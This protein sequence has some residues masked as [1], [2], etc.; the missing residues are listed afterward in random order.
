VGGRR[1]FGLTEKAQQ[2][3]QPDRCLHLNRRG[4]CRTAI[5]G[6]A[7]STQG[8]TGPDLEDLRETAR[9]A[10]A[11]G[12]DLHAQIRDLT[13]S[14]FAT[15]TLDM[16][17]VREVTRSV[18]QGVS[19]ATQ[20]HGGDAGK[21]VRE[22]IAAIEDAILQAAQASTLAVREAGDRTAQ[23][24]SQDLKRALDDLAALQAMLLE[25]FSDTV[26]AG[27][28]TLTAVLSDFLDHARN[29]GEA[30]GQRLAEGLD[31]LQRQLPEAGKQ[32]LQ[33]G[34]DAV[35]AGASLLTQVASG[36][37]VGIGES[38]RSRHDQPAAG[39]DDTTRSD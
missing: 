15:G 39:H 19:D 25:A 24:S 20:A 21:R 29:S 8:Q 38:L 18:L 16:E 6:M 7:M 4:R 23:F 37:L 30:F 28:E 10:A 14:A 32:S 31:A 1:N 5:G 27:R 35:S 11:N 36:V 17:R 22:S 12:A 33:Q 13:R 9:E 3:S 26:G 34:A 2:N